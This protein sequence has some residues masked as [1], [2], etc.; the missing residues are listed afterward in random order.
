[1][2]PYIRLYFTA[3]NCIGLVSNVLGTEP[4]CTIIN[5]SVCIVSIQ[6]VC[7]FSTFKL[8]I[9]LLPHPLPRTWVPV[10]TPGRGQV[11]FL[12]PAQASR[13]IC[14]PGTCPRLIWGGQ[15]SISITTISA[16]DHS[17]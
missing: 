12:P 9:D 14:A 7:S 16:R 8:V 17:L 1:M 6:F 15:C 5:M 4:M 11:R 2:L 3:Q 13:A 10:P